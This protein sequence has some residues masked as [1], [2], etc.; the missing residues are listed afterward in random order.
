LPRGLGLLPLTAL[1]IALGVSGGS[2]WAYLASSGSGTGTAAVGAP[3]ST[4]LRASTGTADL[5]P[6]TNGAVYFTLTNSNK[7]SESFTSVTSASV[8]S[9]DT[10]N[11]PNTNV[12][13]AQTLPYAFSPSVTVGANSTSG[14][15]S[16]ANLVT[17]SASAPN[18]CQGVS[19]TVT[20]TLSGQTS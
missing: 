18:G 3:I 12:S 10:V 11:C 13:I 14:T 20:M 17:L 6:G 16:I 8:V 15:E 9:N 2:A 5:F 19:F 7:L 4:S 1:V